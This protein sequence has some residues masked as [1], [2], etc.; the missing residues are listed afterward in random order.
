MKNCVFLYIVLLHLLSSALPQSTQN[1]LVPKDGHPIASFL[2]PGTP[3]ISCSTI[4]SLLPLLPSKLSTLAEKTEV[5]KHALVLPRNY[6]SQN[7]T[8]LLSYKIAPLPCLLL[9]QQGFSSY[10]L[11]TIPNG[12]CSHRQHDLC[13]LVP[14]RYY[15]NVFP[16]GRN[17]LLR[18]SSPTKSRSIQSLFFT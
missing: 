2:R 4:Y 1:T 11:D 16:I 9:R 5:Y 15:I 13:S 18:F 12:I 6:L 10:I 3:Q 14:Q 17:T 7:Q 8:L